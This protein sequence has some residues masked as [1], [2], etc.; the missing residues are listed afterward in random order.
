ML[1]SEHHSVFEDVDGAPELKSLLGFGVELALP[2]FVSSV[3]SLLMQRLLKHSSLY[4][5]CWPRWLD[6]AVLFL[7]FQ[8]HLSYSTFHDSHSSIRYIQEVV[9]FFGL[10]LALQQNHILQLL[11]HFNIRHFDMH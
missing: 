7:S 10:L 2:F 8:L 1:T 4:C 11:K 5:S 9:L 6:A 3:L